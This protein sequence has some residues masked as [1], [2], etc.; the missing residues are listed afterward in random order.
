M[1]PAVI[2]LANLALFVAFFFAGFIALS[3][4]T[5][6][7]I[8]FFQGAR[9]LVYTRGDRISRRRHTMLL[10]ILMVFTL[11]I[12]TGIFLGMGS[13]T[14]SSFTLAPTIALILGNLAS[15]HLDGPRLMP[16]RE[17]PKD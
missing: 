6:K 12:S 3:Y 13:L 15:F 17:L 8:G 10:L 5:A 9:A 14:W 11:A 7:T 4:L 1:H 2:V 16:T